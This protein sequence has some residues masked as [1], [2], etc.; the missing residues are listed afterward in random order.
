MINLSALFSR[1]LV[2]VVLII[3]LIFTTGGFTAFADSISNVVD[4]NKCKLIDPTEL[5]HKYYDDTVGASYASP[6]D[7][8]S[9][10]TDSNIL[11]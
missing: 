6:S 2:S 10:A 8:L 3:S 11:K 7:A 4:T 5:S 9:L 1:R